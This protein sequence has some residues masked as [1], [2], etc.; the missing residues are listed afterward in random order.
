M[1]AAAL[2][3]ALS[4]ALMHATWNYLVKTAR[5]RL[6]TAW[7][8]VV[9]GAAAFSPVVVAAGG[10]DRS[11]WGHIV[12]SGVIHTIYALTLTR[13]YE[14]GDLSIAYPVARGLAPMLVAL[15]ALVFL[16]EQLGAVAVAGLAVVSV[17]LLFVAYE[18][19]ALRSSGWAVATGFVIAAYTVVDASGVRAADHALAYTTA[20]FIA[21]AV[22]LTP[23][24]IVLRSPGEIGNAIAAERLRTVLAGLLSLGAYALVLGAALLAPIGLVAAVRET[25]IVF[26][27]LAGAVL[28]REGMGMRRVSGS[29]AIVV[30]V[31]LLGVS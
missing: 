18:P 25:S 8:L 7:A 15:G 2:M 9:A 17:A 5:D 21:N 3:L 12:A 27:A 26:G 14:R 19:G 16:S 24:V 30:G 4:S 13:A 23:L 22:M 20:V 28:L 6:V 11:A 29:A 10:V 31:V 1:P